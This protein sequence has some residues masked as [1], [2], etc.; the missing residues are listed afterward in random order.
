M[1]P[2][3]E[4]E[5]VGFGE[6]GFVV[7]EGIKAGFTMVRAHAAVADTAEGEPVDGKVD[8]GIV[9]APATKGEVL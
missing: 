7:R 5:P 6:H 1:V 4:V 2:E 8:D 3:G 9:D